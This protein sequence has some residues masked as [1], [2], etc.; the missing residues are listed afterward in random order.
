MTCKYCLREIIDDKP[1]DVLGVCDKCRT[2]LAPDELDGEAG[3]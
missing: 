1:I 3:R 2:E